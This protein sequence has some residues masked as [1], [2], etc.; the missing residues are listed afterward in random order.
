VVNRVLPDEVTDEYFAAWH[1]SQKKY[2]AMVDVAFSP[3]PIRRTPLFDHEIVGLESL[4]EMAD[5]IFGDTDPTQHFHTTVSQSLKKVGKNYELQLQ[6]P[7]V[8]KEDVD[9]THRPGELFVSVGPYKREI[10]L[11][12]VLN[13]TKVTRGKLEEGVLRVTFSGATK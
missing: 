13:G 5:A 9:I 12:R 10:S 4:G 11:P 2:D 7:F 1:R 3:V 6:L 8:S